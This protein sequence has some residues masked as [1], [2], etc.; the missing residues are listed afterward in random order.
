MKSSKNKKKSDRREFLRN[1]IALGASA[2]AGSACTT[3]CTGPSLEANSDKVRV[4]TTDGKLI[5]VDRAMVEENA[6]P[7]TI[8]RKR[9]TAELEQATWPAKAPS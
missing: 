7:K 1:S 3:G 2:V 8:G 9:L 4:L 6:A 5:E